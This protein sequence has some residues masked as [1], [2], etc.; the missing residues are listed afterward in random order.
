MDANKIKDTQNDT[1]VLKCGPDNDPI[2][3]RISVLEKLRD[4][5]R[6]ALSEAN[7]IADYRKIPF[8]FEMFMT[9]DHATRNQ[10]ADE[11][12]N[13]YEL[14]RYAIVRINFHVLD[15]LYCAALSWRIKDVE[16]TNYA[17]KNYAQLLKARKLL[18]V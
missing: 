9:M 7:A 6:L 14:M 8:G 17:L 5:A 4:N 15:T 16:S 2:V 13:D 18:G 3:L 12:R 1:V 10:I 11:I